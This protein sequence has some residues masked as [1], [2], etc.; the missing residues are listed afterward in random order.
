LQYLAKKAYS[1]TY[2]ARN[3]RR[4]IQKEVEDNVTELIVANY[5]APIRDLR[6]DVSGEKVEVFPE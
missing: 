6:L 5:A 4:L 1:F 2:G 3:L